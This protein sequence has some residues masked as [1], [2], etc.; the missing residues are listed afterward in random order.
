MATTHPTGGPAPYRYVTGAV[1]PNTKDHATFRSKPPAYDDRTGSWDSGAGYERWRSTEHDPTK[2]GDRKT[3][4]YASHH[5]LLAVV[6]CYPLDAPLGE[7]LAD[8]DGSDVHHTTGSK[9]CN[10][11]ESPNFDDGDLPHSHGSG[12]GIEVL[13]HGTHS[14]RTQAQVRA[15]GEDAKRAARDDGP[16]DPDRCGRCDGE[17]DTLWQCDD[18]EGIRCTECAKR[19]TDGAALEVA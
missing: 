15:W 10:F 5:R 18:F 13:D 16:V 19:G 1:H 3:D 14:E 2:P 6:E 11:G 12:R 4:V 17:T 8:L 9:W 7:I